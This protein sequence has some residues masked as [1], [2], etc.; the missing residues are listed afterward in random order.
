MKPTN[1]DPLCIKKKK[2]ASTAPKILPEL[3]DYYCYIWERN[4]VNLYLLFNLAT[5]EQRVRTPAAA[6]R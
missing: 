4:H 2:N 6:G 5:T 1:Q 3:G